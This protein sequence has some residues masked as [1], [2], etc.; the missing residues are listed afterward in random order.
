[1]HTTALLPF[2]GLVVKFRTTDKIV[3]EI[4]SFDWYLNYPDI[5]TPC[6][7][8]F[9]IIPPEEIHFLEDGNRKISSTELVKRV[10]AFTEKLL[11]KD[12]K[13]WKRFLKYIETVREAEMYVSNFKQLAPKS[14]KLAKR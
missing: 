8:P 10:D 5:V 7:P 11:A 9:E 4:S 2:Q 6:R 14:K 1:M 12:V 3:E 13:T